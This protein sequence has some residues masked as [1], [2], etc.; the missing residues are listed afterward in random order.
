MQEYRNQEVIDWFYGKRDAL[1]AQGKADIASGKADRYVIGE[2]PKKGMT[3]I[4]ND[5][6]YTVFSTTEGGTV[7]LRLQGGTQKGLD[8]EG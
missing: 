5:L 3:L 1:E 8:L 2:L 4:I 6:K 7:V